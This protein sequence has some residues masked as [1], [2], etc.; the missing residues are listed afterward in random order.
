MT[1]GS[2]ITQN[3]ADDRL[4]LFIEEK[5]KVDPEQRV[6]AADAYRLFN[7]WYEPREEHPLSRKRIGDAFRR[8]GYTRR[9]LGGHVYWEGVTLA[10]E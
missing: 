6:S 9:Q 3:Y 8:L 4:A 7:I 1:S 5:G 2:V 10:E